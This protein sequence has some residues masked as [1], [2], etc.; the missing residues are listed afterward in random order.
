MRDGEEQAPLLP[1]L[2]ES[3]PAI[4][5]TEASAVVQIMGDGQPQPRRVG[6]GGLPGRGIPQGKDRR[7]IGNGDLCRLHLNIEIGVGLRATTW[8][9][10]QH[11]AA[12]AE[13]GLTLDA[14][15]ARSEVAVVGIDGGGLDDLLG[16]SVVGRC[17]ETQNW[18]VWCH[19]W[20]QPEVFKQRKEIAPRLMDFAA[21]GDLTV[22]RSDE[23]TSDIDD[24]ADVIERLLNADLL[25]ADSAVGS[26]PSAWPRS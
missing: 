10:A 6:V 23:P 11:R 5:K 9:G 13:P 26:I 22:V 17:R 21:A 7:A 1:I 2:Y 20:A 18:L 12:A 25:P 4:A 8:I 16:L 19:A 14:I 24:L 15:I 3:P